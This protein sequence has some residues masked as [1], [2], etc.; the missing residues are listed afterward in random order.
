MNTARDDEDEFM[1]IVYSCKRN[2]V[3]NSLNIILIIQTLAVYYKI[4]YRPT[5]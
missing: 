5:K 4:H 3:S 2:F 1:L